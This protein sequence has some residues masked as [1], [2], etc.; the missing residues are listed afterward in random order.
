MIDF[1][2]LNRRLLADAEGLLRK[3]LPGGRSVGKEYICAGL[4]GGEGRS[5]SIN[6]T[7]GKW[8]DFSNPDLRGRDLI[9]LFSQ[10]HGLKNGEAAKELERD[11]G[12]GAATPPP[13]KPNGHAKTNQ[14][15]HAPPDTLPHQ[16]A[17][18]PIVVPDNAPRPSFRHPKHGESSKQW[19]YRNAAGDLIGYVA[20][21]DPPDGKKQYCPFTWTGKKWQPR[22]WLDP[23]PLYGADDLKLRPEAPVLVV[24]GE[25]S[26]DAA[27]KLTSRYVVVT[28]PGGASR[29]H[30]AD[31]RALYGRQIMFWPDN[32][33][34]GLQAMLGIAAILTGKAEY[35]ML[36][37]PKDKPPRWDAADAVSDGWTT[38]DLQALATTGAY[39]PELQ[40]AIA[41]QKSLN[42]DC[43][44]LWLDW[45]LDRQGNGVP[46][47]NLANAFRILTSDAELKDL[48]WYDQ[49]MQRVLTAVPPREWT[50]V[51]D[52]RLQLYMQS[53]LGI[54]KI[55]KETVQDAIV[56]Y[57][58]SRERNCVKD[59][60]ESLVWDGID[61]LPDFFPDYYGTPKTAYTQAVGV[62]FWISVVARVYLPG[63]Q[64]D[65]VLV[66]EGSQGLHKSRS[67]R[68]I[69]GAWFCEQHESV[70]DP[71]KFAEILQGKLIIEVAEG[72]AFRRSNSRRVKAA[73]S[74]PMDRYRAPWQHRA[75][76]HPRQCVFVITT[77][78]ETWGED[79]TGGRRW[80]PISVKTD[81]DVEGI[82]VSRDQLFAEA[83]HRFKRAPLDASAE[84]RT[85]AGAS[86]WHTPLDE[87]RIEQDKR[88]NEDVWEQTI[89]EH[90]EFTRD[91]EGTLH[92]RTLPID[93][94]SIREVL[95]DIIRIPE[96]RRGR[97]EQMRVAAIFK[98]MG[99]HRHSLRVGSGRNWIYSSR[100]DMKW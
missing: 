39:L 64:V 49:F 7:T 32:D 83:V 60:F 78:E 68:A 84:A 80:W 52:I 51:D 28:W 77:N 98:H 9:S 65:N 40:T 71:K 27:R 58:R 50:D 79:E 67:L 29:W 95:A 22:G 18:T 69:G 82:L 59:W 46:Q 31:W 85:A 13:I 10:I 96:E 92:P 91:P 56:A 54:V 24:E 42:L 16:S 21:Y 94:L 63:C 5:C 19:A 87:T 93:T 72:D 35:R 74:N 48:V 81:V 20:R 37:P 86:W 2:G 97:R 55:G 76:D 12:N 100:E 57:A 45:G 15:G 41:P 11:Y 25:A 88:F 53:D 43:Q 4:Q 73:V 47:P 3:W 70:D 38:T 30:K 1:Q 23:Q 36:R 44:T 17:S 14:N 90:L 26:A 75:E 66:L 34:P 61:R 6:L 99:W 89:R 33:E 62:N 8:S